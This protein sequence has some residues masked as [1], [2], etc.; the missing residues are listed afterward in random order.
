MS[1]TSTP[2]AWPAHIAWLLA[3]A[4]AV[5]L[6]LGID[7]G[8]RWSEAVTLRYGAALLALFGVGFLMAS[9]YPDRSIVY[10]YLV[11]TARRATRWY[12]LDDLSGGITRGRPSA[13]GWLCLGLAALAGLG[14]LLV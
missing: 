10:R 4:V 6:L 11:W 8:E 2:P 1:E 14:S 12:R 7:G 3:A 5:L 9:T 13:A